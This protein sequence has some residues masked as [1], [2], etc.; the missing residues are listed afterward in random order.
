MNINIIIILLAS[1]L[2]A[3]INR[4]YK[5]YQN[6][7]NLHEENPTYSSPVDLIF[8]GKR[9]ILNQGPYELAG[10]RHRDC[11]GSIAIVR[12]Y[13]NSEGSHI[14]KSKIQGININHGVIFNGKVYDDFPQLIFTYEQIKIKFQSLIGLDV[15]PLTATAF[16]EKG[17]CNIAASLAG[18]YQNEKI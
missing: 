6:I 8:L 11:S 3:P 5:H 1:T 13:R 16:A 18:F 15:T 12:L 14:L 10:Y 7:A 9:P 2:I 4:V 17:S